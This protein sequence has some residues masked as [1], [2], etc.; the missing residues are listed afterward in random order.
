MRAAGAEPMEPYQGSGIPWRCRCLTCGHEITPRLGNVR[1][2]NRPCKY[3][4]SR[5]F[6]GTQPGVV[7][8]FRHDGHGA[9]K[10]GITN[11]RIERLIAHER[12]GW[13]LVDFWSFDTG[14]DARYVEVAVL[15]AWGNYAYGVV[16]DDMPQAGYTETVSLDDVSAAEAVALIK[17]AIAD[18]L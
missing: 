7:Y 8:L 6:D 14:A 4:S 11:D 2:G 17:S 3:C 5:G 15:E 12:Q 13:S 18:L 1:S 10:V 16:E 9:L